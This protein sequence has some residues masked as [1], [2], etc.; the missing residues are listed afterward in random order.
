VVLARRSQTV[1]AELLGRSDVAR[2]GGVLNVSGHLK[3]DA[4]RACGLDQRVAACV[5]DSDRVDEGVNQSSVATQRN[6]DTGCSQALGVLLAFVAQG[7]EAGDRDV[8]G[9]H[10]GQVVGEQW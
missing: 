5:A 3:A 9:R 7:I 10:S 6:R 1:A 8:G 2:G 4:E